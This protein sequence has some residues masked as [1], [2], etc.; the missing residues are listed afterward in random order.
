MHFKV[1][2]NN[3]RYLSMAP[4]FLENAKN[5]VKMLRYLS[6]KGTSR[7]LNFLRYLKVPYY[8]WTVKQLLKLRYLEAP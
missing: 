4:I 7:Y 3:L 1:P 2:W 6:F 8:D 5:L